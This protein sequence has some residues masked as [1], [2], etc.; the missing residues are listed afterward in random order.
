[1]YKYVTYNC[2]YQLRFLHLFRKMTSTGHFTYILRV[3]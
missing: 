3:L 2:F 1:M